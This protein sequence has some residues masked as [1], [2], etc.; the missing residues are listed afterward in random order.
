MLAP[1]NGLAATID[2]AVKVHLLEDLD[3]AGLEVGLEREIRMI[4]IGVDTQALEAVA[5]NVHVLLGPLVA[6]TAKRRLIDFS[7]FLG[8]E[9]L[10]DHVLD[11]LAMA[12]PT[13]N[14]RSIEAALSM[15]FDNE[16][17]QDL[18]EGVANVDGAVGI[19][20]TIMQN[21]RLAVLI[22]LENLPIQVLLFPLG[23][24]LGLPRREVSLHREIGLGK[25]HGAFIR[26]SH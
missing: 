4:P 9:L 25:V 20:R 15:A 7:H 11:R 17:L 18:V 21:T 6:K 3:V 19:R 16:V 24:T 2:L 26:V 8:A 14:I 13:R 22:L 5:L 23:Q 10:L 1:V 12:V